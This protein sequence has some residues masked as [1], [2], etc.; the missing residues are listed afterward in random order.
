MLISIRFTNF[1]RASGLVAALLVAAGCS[2]GGGA[3]SAPTAAAPTAAASTAAESAAP[4]AAAASEAASAAPSAASGAYTLTI[5][6]SATVGK[7]LSGED[8]KTLYEFSVDSTPN[9][10]ACTGSC[11]TNWPPFVLDT[12][13]T[14]VAGAGVTGTIATFARDDGSTQVSYNGKP[15]YYFANDK[16]AGDTNGQ[17]IAGKWK[18]AAP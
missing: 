10:S 18:V 1:S 6:T 12:G 14:A 4:S 2:S 9:K 11:A 16:A 15:L 7:Y 5:V 3:S 13:E 8:G 17:G